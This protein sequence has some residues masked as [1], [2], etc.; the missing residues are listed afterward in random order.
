MG[1]RKTRR[2]AGAGRKITRQH[3]P[4]RQSRYGRTTRRP[5]EGRSGQPNAGGRWNRGSAA[6]DSL[7]NRRRRFDSAAPSRRQAAS[8]HQAAS[9]ARQ[10]V[11]ARWF[12]FACRI[13][14]S[15]RRP[16]RSDQG[17]AAALAANSE[18]ES[19][20]WRKRRPLCHRHDH[21]AQGKSLAK[22]DAPRRVR[23]L[24][25]RSSRRRM[26]VAG[27]RLDCRGARRATRP[28][29]LAPR[30]QWTVSTAGIEDRR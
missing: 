8:L 12:S 9:L 1:R 7:G 17:S 14:R 6:G 28:T 10:A 19:V 11:A 3:R 15:P 18:N 26:Y 13:V 21:L 23:L 20:A 22:L 29:H 27:R 4:S 30:R 16:A 25:R 5:E 2:R 24:P